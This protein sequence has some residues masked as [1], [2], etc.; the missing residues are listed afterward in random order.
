MAE[1]IEVKP[2]RPEPK[3]LSQWKQALVLFQQDLRELWKTPYPRPIDGKILNFE[4][5]CKKISK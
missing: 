5:T 1:W 4:K 2:R 3:T